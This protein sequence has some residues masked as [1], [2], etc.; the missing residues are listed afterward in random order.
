[1]WDI[2]ADVNLQST[3]ADRFVWR[4]SL[5]GRYSVSS[6]YRAFFHGSA[7]LLGAKELWAVRAPPR[8]KLFFW[9]ALHK[10][11]WTAERHK[12]HGLQDGDECTLCAQETETI[13]H[14][15]LGC[16]FAKQVWFA[17]LHPLRLDTLMPDAGDEIASW[18]LHQ[19]SRIASADR[20]VFDSLLF[21]VAS[22]LWKERNVRVFGRPASCVNDVV[23][24]VVQE[25]EEWALAGF[26]PFVALAELWTHN[27]VSM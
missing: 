18:W 1:V 9:L 23:R 25:G 15:V 12:C 16:T 13:G 19:R 26:L 4:W 24:E 17:L 7:S 3:L 14:L 10:R 2:L 6:T 27:R 5:D 8:V 20:K 22:C 21:L 11:L